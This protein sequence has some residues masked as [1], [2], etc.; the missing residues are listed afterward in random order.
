[1]GNATRSKCSMAGTCLQFTGRCNICRLKKMWITS[2][3]LG[4]L[5]VSPRLVTEEEEEIFVQIEL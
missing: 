4:M 3:G 5:F 2:S 1:M